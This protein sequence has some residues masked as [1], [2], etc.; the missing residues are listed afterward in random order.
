MSPDSEE[1]PE[2]NGCSAVRHLI[3]DDGVGQFRHQVHEG[4]A[5]ANCK[6]DVAGPTARLDTNGR[7]RRELEICGLTDS[8]DVDLVSAEI[9]DEDERTGR[10]E[11]GLVRVRGT[12]SV[13]VGA[14]TCDLVL[15]GLDERQMRRVGN[16]PG[17]QC[18]GGTVMQ[19]SWWSVTP[20]SSS[21]F[22]RGSKRRT[23][24]GS[25]LH[26]QARLQHGTRMELTHE[27]V[28]STTK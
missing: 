11:K 28:A 13:R 19:M 8:I 5:M 14:R 10:I 22:S 6:G 17:S 27:R 25:I 15:I 21:F 2:L 20:Q 26:W 23:G 18:S 9:R 12:L 3:A 4:F 16:I 7:Q 1:L 24:E